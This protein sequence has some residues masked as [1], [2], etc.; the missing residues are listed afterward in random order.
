MKGAITNID[1]K[2]VIQCPWCG[3]K[4]SE[5]LYNTD[6]NCEVKKCAN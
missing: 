6:Y 4:E 2:N 1:I 5:R 3:G